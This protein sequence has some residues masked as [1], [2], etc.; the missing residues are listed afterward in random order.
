[1]ALQPVE[2]TLIAASVGAVASTCAVLLT[3][4]LARGRDRRHKVWDRRMDTYAEVIRSRRAMSRTRRD[5]LREKTFPDGPLDPDHEGKAFGL[6]EAQLEMFGSPEVIKLG[7]ESFDALKGWMV[8]LLEWRDLKM[9]APLDD[10]LRLKA[11]AKWA[12]FEK[13]AEIATAADEKL[14]EAI[15]REAKFRRSKRE[16]WARLAFWRD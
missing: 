10:D 15:K 7:D 16:G 8:A 9:L 14:N 4:L 5:V 11:E 1:M 13:R 6:T 2:A 12:E 3:H